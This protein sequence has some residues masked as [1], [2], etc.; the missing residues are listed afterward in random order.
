MLIQPYIFF[1]GRCEEAAEFYRH[2]L[3]AEV[4]ALVR[5]KDS[6][7]PG[8][9]P[10]EDGNK[11][12]HMSLRIGETTLLASDGRCEGKPSFQG[13]SLSLTVAGEADAERLFGA[14]AE[15]GKVQMPL[16]KTFFSPSFGMVTDR[17]GVPWMIH[18]AP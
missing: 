2:A 4:T 16:A 8:M 5:F 7:D 14:L 11:V 6:P 1:D 3:G 17:F 15:G 10:A 13:F 12:M 18:V 9:C